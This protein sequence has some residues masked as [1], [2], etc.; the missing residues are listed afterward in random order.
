MAKPSISVLVIEDEADVA[1]LLERTL[2]GATEAWFVATVSSTLAESLR[3]LS[4]KRFDA[5]VLDL[6][7][8]DSSGVRGVETLRSASAELPIIVVSGSGEEGVVFE[9]MRRGAQEYMIKGPAVPAMLA[10]SVTYA[11]SRRQS[12]LAMERTLAKLRRML[13]GTVSVLAAAL[14]TKDPYTAGHERRVARLACAI[15]RGMGFTEDE[16]EGVHVAGTLHDIGKIAVPAEILAK[17]SPL[18]GIE[19][20]LVK[21]HPKIGCDILSGVEFPW[22]VAEIV[23]QHHERMN[24]TGY[25]LG[26]KGDAIRREAQILA[27]ADVIEAMSSHRP[28]RV[29]LGSGAA[30]SE[31]SENRGILYAPEPV[32]ICLRLFT[33]EGYVLDERESA[34]GERNVWLE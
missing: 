18:T 12:E 11:I 21:T 33:T 26:L 28:Y 19:Y 22:P 9:A 10:R 8:P 27:V 5:A 1:H 16:V 20:D 24:G 23:H 32:D 4:T 30:L 25:P 2:A 3:L 14:E 7:L 13:H 31:I 34:G 29:A 15:A 6:G 17:P